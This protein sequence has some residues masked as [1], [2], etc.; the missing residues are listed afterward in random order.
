[1]GKKCLTCKP[2]NKTI[3]NTEKLVPLWYKKMGNYSLLPKSLNCNDKYNPNKNELKSFKPRITDTEV[4][5]EVKKKKDGYTTGQQCQ[6]K[7]VKK[8][9]PQKKHIKMKKILVWQNQMKMVMYLLF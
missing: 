5:V 2:S 9:F 8:Y 7:K 4:N 1:M 6:L 3:V